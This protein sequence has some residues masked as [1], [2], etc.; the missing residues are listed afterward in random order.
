MTINTIYGGKNCL[1]KYRCH[2]D[3]EPSKYILSIRYIEKI[4]FYMLQIY[5]LYKIKYNLLNNVYLICFFLPMT[6]LIWWKNSCSYT[7]TTFV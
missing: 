1:K 5:M 7:C 3:Q 2:V 6:L 4:V